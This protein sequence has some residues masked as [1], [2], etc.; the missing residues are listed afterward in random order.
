MKAF[1][2]ILL[3]ISS[4]YV[5][6]Q[7]SSISENSYIINV[8]Y[9]LGKTLRKPLLLTEPFAEPY[10]SPLADHDEVIG[11][12][13]LSYQD[14]VKEI[15]LGS[16]KPEYFFKTIMPTSPTDKR[17]DVSII[18]SGVG[19]A[20]LDMNTGKMINIPGAFDAVPSIDGEIITLPSHNKTNNRF[21]IYQRDNLTQ[22]IFQ[23]DDSDPGKLIGVYQSV[24]L[25][26]QDTSGKVYR[27][28]TDVLT[29]SNTNGD[30]SHLRG[31]N[32]LFRDYRVEANKKVTP[33]EVSQPLCHNL[34]V[35]LKLPMISKNGKK[36]AAYNS[37]T[38]TTVIYKVL[39][40][41]QN[42][43]VCEVET[44][45]GFA[46]TKVEF[47]EDSSLI[48]FA[49]DSLATHNG[50]IRWHAQPNTKSMNMNVYVMDLKNK[51]TKRISNI[52]SGNAYYP[53]FSRDNTVTFLQQIPVGKEADYSV[54]QA[55]YSLEDADPFVPLS[56]YRAD[57]LIGSRDLPIFAL[58][59]LWFKM[60]S[61]INSIPTPL[62]A[63]QL[64]TK[65]DPNKCK[66][67]VENYWD[68]IKSDL[69][70]ETLFA[71]DVGE[72]DDPQ[73]ILSQEAIFQSM[74]ELKVEDLL[75]ICPK[76]VVAPA[77]VEL[78]DARMVDLKKD[79]DVIS[80]RCAAC[81]VAGAG[82]KFIVGDKKA[83][84]QFKSLAI[85]HVQN[86]FMPMGVTLSPNEKKEVLEKLSKL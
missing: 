10:K 73:N 47:N 34:E 58:G 7:L 17:N 75:S 25:V 48:T 56:N 59:K 27:V 64:A 74:R 84:K 15:K 32:L 39:R 44:D 12:C 29:P 28:I 24:G 18:I 63:K 45:L 55:K 53:S 42:E 76:K 23:E 40:N 85:K 31:K 21:T 51:K 4:N 78:L 2:R 37:Q 43:S 61:Q 50:S 52:N 70:I 38:G 57:C 54:I 13:H 14:D 11:L 83:M 72:K 35:S 8:N 86:G 36:L 9:S 71:K 20:L 65:I 62:A 60:C 80:A 33:V 30:T 41:D 49:S 69:S 22:P 68:Q 82:R 81:H 46:S 26:D 1:L 67:I 16:V 19:N 79:S 5:Y 6:S 66:T 3:L 77:K